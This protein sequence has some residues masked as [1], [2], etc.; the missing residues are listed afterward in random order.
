MQ[1][2]RDILDKQVVDRQQTKIGKVD[3]VV[4]ELREGAPPK[5]AFVELGAVALGRRLGPRAHRW[6]GRLAEKLGGP[7]RRQPHRI[8]WNKLRDTGVDIESDIDVRETAIFDWQVWLR[9]RV[10]GRIP[11]A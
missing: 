10:I 6:V 9:D 11:G 5:I 2:I 7:R 4:A 8:A 3:G 1:M